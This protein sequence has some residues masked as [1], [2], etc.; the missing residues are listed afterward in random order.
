[1]LAAPMADRRRFPRVQAPVLY[2]PAGLGFVHHRRNTHNISLGGMR[3]FSDENLKL[4]SRLEL[5]VL[6]PDESIVRCWAEVVWVVAADPSTS[7]EFEVG[8][9]FTDMEEPD[10]RRLASVLNSA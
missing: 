6:L 10:V 4:G 1:M 5:D 3:V 8:L 7:A 9:R 2:R